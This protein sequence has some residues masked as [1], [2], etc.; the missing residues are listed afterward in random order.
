MGPNVVRLLIGQGT[1]C[2]ADAD[3]RA[4]PRL[5]DHVWTTNELLSYRVS[6]ARREQLRESEHLFPSWGYR[7]YWRFFY[8][9]GGGQNH[10]IAQQS[11]DSD[12]VFGPTG[13][14]VR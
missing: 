8:G 4:R 7:R 5:T 10:Y 3:T 2:R 14:K 13:G 11:P 6:A 12:D 9:S 1:H